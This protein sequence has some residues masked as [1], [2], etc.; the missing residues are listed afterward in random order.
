MSKEVHVRLAS[1]RC[2]VNK[3]LWE[4]NPTCL[5]V[6]CGPFHV[7]TAG[8][9]CDRAPVSCKTKNIHYLAFY[10]KTF[11]DPYCRP[12]ACC[13]AEILMGATHTFKVKVETIEKK[14]KMETCLISSLPLDM[15]QKHWPMQQGKKN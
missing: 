11:A 9:S 14:A 13:P 3:V 4:H 2:S 6:V 15:A 12:A 7:T 10:E 5:H 1:W 8:L